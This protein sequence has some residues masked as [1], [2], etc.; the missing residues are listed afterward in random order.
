MTREQMIDEL[1][2]GVAFESDRVIERQLNYY[3]SLSTEQIAQE[4]RKVYGTE[5]SRS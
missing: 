4:Y 2:E 5:L 3:A 1:M